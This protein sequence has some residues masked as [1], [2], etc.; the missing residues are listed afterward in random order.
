MSSR[1]ISVVTQG[2]DCISYA[3]IG[4]VS[5]SAVLFHRTTHHVDPARCHCRRNLDPHQ[6]ALND[7]LLIAYLFALL[8]DDFIDITLI[9]YYFT[10]MKTGTIINSLPDVLLPSWSEERNVWVD[11]DGQDLQM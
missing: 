10:A 4:Y 8:R 2:T 5:E 11:Q 1:Q 3:W 9:P 7:N 6:E